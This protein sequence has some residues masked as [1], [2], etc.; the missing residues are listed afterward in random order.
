MKYSKSTILHFY[1]WYTLYYTHQVFKCTL[2]AQYNK[3]NT[4]N[5][6]LFRFY[7]TILNLQHLNWIVKIPLLQSVVQSEA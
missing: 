1:V 3:K 4:K 6:L 5:V 2:F 7:A